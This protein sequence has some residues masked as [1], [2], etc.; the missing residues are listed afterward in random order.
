MQL[1]ERFRPGQTPPTTLGASREYN[2][3]M[4]PK[5]I[6]AYG[7]LVR[8]APCYSLGAGVH[9][10]KLGTWL[11]RQGLTQQSSTTGGAT[12]VL[13]DHGAVPCTAARAGMGGT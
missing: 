3:D 12:D 8:P 13:Q 1:W 6:M 11:Y 2:V 9:V 7:N 10:A 4:V 5:F